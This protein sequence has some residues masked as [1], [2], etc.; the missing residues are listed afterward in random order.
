MSTRHLTAACT[1][2]FALPALVHSAD[3]PR[4]FIL[5]GIVLAKNRDQLRTGDSRL[6]PALDQLKREADR[7]LQAGPF[8]V[9]QKKNAPPS[10]DMHDYM[11]YAP[12]WWPK[13]DTPDGLPYVRRDGQ[14]NPDVPKLSDRNKL[15]AMVANVE[16]LALAY[17]FTGA[18]RYAAYALKLLRAWFIEPNTR[19]NPH[20]RYA[21]SVRGRDTGRG[22]GLIES[23][24][25]TELVDAV[26]LLAESKAWTTDDDRELK[27]WFDEFLH[28]MLDTEM[29][30]YEDNAKNNHGTYYD[31]QVA[32]YALF[33][34]RPELARKVLETARAKRIALQ[35]EPDGR[36]PLELARTKAWGYSL[37]NLRGLMKLARLGEHV[38]VDLWSFKTEDGRSIRA[39]VEFLAP[40]G[41]DGKQWPYEQLGGFSAGASHPIFRQAAKHYPEAS[42]SARIK[43]RSPKPSDRENLTSR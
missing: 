36:Q 10:G 33:L 7:A 14:H 1:L 27:K 43:S 9:M 32:S 18:E 41:L 28:W 11:S 21:Q 40:Y 39:A 38:D 19:M 8:S 20:F 23:H 31:V 15:D 25:L 30:R 35:V 4:V 2:A 5:D 26:G 13:P 29:G 12:Y 24:C 6:A 37:A 22:L 16:T 34:D 17:Y 42:F 3:A